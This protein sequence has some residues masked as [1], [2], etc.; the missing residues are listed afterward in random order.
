MMFLQSAGAGW[1]HEDADIMGTRI[2]VELFHANPEL[3]RQGIDTV[4]REMY[5]DQLLYSLVS[6]Y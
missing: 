6:Y 3:A 4:L 5:V 1:L 2:S